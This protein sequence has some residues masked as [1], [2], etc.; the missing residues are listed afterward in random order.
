MSLYTKDL[1]LTKANDRNVN[2]LVQNFVDNDIKNEIYIENQQAKGN[3]VFRLPNGLLNIKSN[4][5]ILF[6]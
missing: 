4:N 6:I 2:I 1:H 5:V 3:D